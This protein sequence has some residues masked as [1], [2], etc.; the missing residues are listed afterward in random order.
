M[1]SEKKNASMILPCE[2]RYCSLEHK[3]ISWFHHDT[4][5]IADDKYDTLVPK[6]GVATRP[7]TDSISTST[8][9]RDRSALYL[10]RAAAIDS[11]GGPAPPVSSWNVSHSSPHTEVE[12]VSMAWPPRPLWLR[13]Q[14]N[15]CEWHFVFPSFL[16]CVQQEFLETPKTKAKSRKVTWQLFLEFLCLTVLC[17][18]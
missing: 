12:D 2:H 15:Q 10:S 14:P 5:L 4:R 3:H 8:S 17:A 13:H 1:Q 18:V 6:R 16:C 11:T 7:T 9:V